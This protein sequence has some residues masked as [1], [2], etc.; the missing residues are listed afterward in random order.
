M[1]ADHIHHLAWPDWERARPRQHVAE[2]YRILD[3][4]LGD[5]LQ[6]VGSATERRRR[7]R[8]GRLRPRRRPADG[9]VNLNAWLAQEGFLTYG[10]AKRRREPRQARRT[11]CSSCG[12]GSRRTL[13]YSFKQRDAVAARARLPAARLL[14]R[15]L[16]AHAGVLLRACSATS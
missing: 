1:A 11:G 3:G 8:D 14:D 10:Q 6:A 2:V 7:G 9:V 12:A 16:A 5:L 4:A 15:R 13:R